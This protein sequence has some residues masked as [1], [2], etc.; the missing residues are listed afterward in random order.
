MKEIR[1]ERPAWTA[2]MCRRAA[3]FHHGAIYGD[4]EPG[5][6]HPDE[7]I[8]TY[9]PALAVSQTI[10]G[11]GPAERSDWMRC[12]IA[13]DDD[14]GGTRGYAEMV[15]ETIEDP[16][17]VVR[18]AGVLYCWDGNHRIGACCLGNV[19]TLP[20]IVGMPREA[21]EHGILPLR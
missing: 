1:D 13:A 7:F 19:A 2:E 4:D 5:G 20:A 15:G 10:D 11:F 16:I 12:E 17:I 3:A 14:D 8:W 9:D 6:G 21:A 18:I